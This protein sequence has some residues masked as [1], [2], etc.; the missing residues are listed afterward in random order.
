MSNCTEV[1]EGDGKPPAV[2]IAREIEQKRLREEA[3]AVEGRAPAEIA[4]SLPG[5]TGCCID[6]ANPD[7]IDALARLGARFEPDID[8]R[9]ADGAAALIAEHHLALDH[10]PIAKLEG[11]FTPDGSSTCKPLNEVELA[12]QPL[13]ALSRKKAVFPF[14]PKVADR[15]PRGSGCKSFM[16]ISHEQRRRR[17][18]EL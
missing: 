10:P 7:R 11:C 14:S 17:N 8:G 5:L 18:F 4:R 3:V 2:E 9:K 16:S 12:T 6:I 1:D 13:E 15:G